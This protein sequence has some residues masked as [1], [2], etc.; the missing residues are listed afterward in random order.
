MHESGPYS[1]MIPCMNGDGDNFCSLSHFF[2]ILHMVSSDCSCFHCKSL[3]A[4]GS[5]SIMVDAATAKLP[6]MA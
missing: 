3:I 6:L 4:A 5:A 2:I 1:L